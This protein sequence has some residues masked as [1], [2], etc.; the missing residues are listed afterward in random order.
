MSGSRRWQPSWP[1]ARR[2]IPT[3]EYAAGRDGCADRCAGGRARRAPCRAT[4][5]SRRGWRRRLIASTRLQPSSPAG[6]T[7]RAGR[8]VAARGGAGGTAGRRSGGGRARAGDRDAP[9]G[10]RRPVRSPTLSWPPA[11]RSSRRGCRRRVTRAAVRRPSR[12][13]AS[14]RCSRRS[15]SSQRGSTP[16]ASCLRS[17]S[18]GGSGPAA[19]SGDPP[20]TEPDGSAS[21]GDLVLGRGAARARGPDR[22]AR[23]TDR[24]GRSGHGRQR[25]GGGALG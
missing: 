15:R 7:P 19:R 6:P 17:G 11:S 20:L 4:P 8:A 1:S 13:R 2:A 16:S 3:L 18:A 5:R 14:R 24:G 10:G 22:M 12:I 23:R 25:S 9:G 21:P